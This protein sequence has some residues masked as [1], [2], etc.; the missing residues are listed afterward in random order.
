MG[1]VLKKYPRLSE[2]F[3]LDEILGVEAAAVEVA[4]FSLRPPDDGH[5]HAQLALVRARAH[6]LPPFGG[7]STMEALQLIPALPDGS[8]RLGRVLA[9]A[10]SLRP[11]RRAGLLVQGLH[12]AKLVGEHRLDHLHAHFMTI[13]SHTAYVAHLL[14][15]VPFTVTA[16]AKDIYRSEVDVRV[17]REVAAAANAVVTVCEANRRY[18]CETLLGAEAARSRVVRVYNGVPIGALTA[19]SAGREPGLVVAAGRLVEKKGFHILFQA[20][21]LLLDSGTP[22]RCVLIG[23]GDQREELA[24][25]RSRLGLEAHVEMAGAMPRE[26]VL[27]WMRRARLLVAPCVTARDGNRD[28]LPTVL[29]EALAL[30]L[31]VVAST[32]GGIPEIVDDGS[33]GLLVEE[34]DPEALAAAVARI[35][36]DEGLCQRLAAAG[37]DK[38]LARFDR[39]QTIPHLV[40]L[41]GGKGPGRLPVTVPA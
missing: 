26:E 21:R 13:A 32:V 41:L 36:T 20:C 14:T 16:H 30:G 31:P 12:L 4:V 34:G 15:D 35:L 40:G 29:L 7:A 28:A 23:D 19:G 10:G 27:G 8:E 5:F 6:Y 9:F 25:L 38:A 24:A 11:E 22:F 33:E 3:I 39:A 17:F 1:Y 37:R 2:T 18:I